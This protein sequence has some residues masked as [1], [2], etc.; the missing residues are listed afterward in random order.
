MAKRVRQPVVQFNGRS[1]IQTHGDQSPVRIILHSTESHDH[2]GVR[3]IEGI[4]NFWKN[5]A[6]GYGSHIIVDKDGNSGFGAP[7]TKICWHT[8]GRNTGSI[9]IEQIGFA[10]FSLH[11]WR[12]TRRKQLDKVARWMAWYS[13]KYDIPLVINVN[14]GVSTHKMQSDRF[15]GTHWDPGYGFPLEW[16]VQKAK[17]YKRW[18]W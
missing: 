12:F 16:V 8:A 5:Q 4:F 6:K 7:A 18:G 15:G 10:R 2:E 17:N 1:F 3:D 11:T 9:G 13:K 14:K